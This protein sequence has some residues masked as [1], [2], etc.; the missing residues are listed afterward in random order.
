MKY[1]FELLNVVLALH[2]LRVLLFLLTC[3]S[4]MMTSIGSYMYINDFGVVKF[5]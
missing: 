4:A 3:M 5:E 2:S 1:V